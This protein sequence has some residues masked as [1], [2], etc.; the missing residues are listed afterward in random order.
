V[1][2][3]SPVTQ[4][5]PSAAAAASLAPT[6]TEEE[7]AR[8]KVRTLQGLLLKHRGGPG[9]GSGRLKAPEA[10][11][12][13]DTLEEV[14]GIM[15]KE[16]GVMNAAV[17]PDLFAPPVAPKVESPIVREAPLPAVDRTPAVLTMAT[18]ETTA[19]ETASPMVKAKLEPDPLAGPVTCLETVLRMYKESASPS[20]RE[21]LLIPLREALMLAAGESNK[22]IAETDL[23]NHRAALASGPPPVDR[24]DDMPAGNMMGFPGA[25]AVARPDADGTE[26]ALP[27]E[28]PLSSGAPLSDS[29]EAERKLREA[30]DALLDASGSD[31][32]LGLRANLSAEEAVDLAEKVRGVKSVLLDEVM[33]FE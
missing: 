28:P 10:K 33:R 23:N 29:N 7:E 8:R 2:P 31:G 13:E 21:A 4:S 9:F 19:P 14:K 3:V 27:A 32:R 5:A 1:Q 16:V 20:E 15:R 24:V 6:S 30:R 17:E 25:R 22:V 12:L 26:D 18:P 11:R